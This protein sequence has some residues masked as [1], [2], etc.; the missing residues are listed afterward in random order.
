MCIPSA[1]RVPSFVCLAVL[2]VSLSLSAKALAERATVRLKDGSAVSGELQTY[3][4]GDH[5]TIVLGGKVVQFAAAETASVELGSKAVAPPRAEPR[6]ALPARKARLALPITLTSIGAATM[7]LGGIV[8]AT[9]KDDQDCPDGFCQGLQNPSAAP[10]GKGMMIGG[11]VVTLV[12]L[13]LLPMELAARV[14]TAEVVNKRSY[15]AERATFSPWFVLRDRSG[16][17]AGLSGA[18]RF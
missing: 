7:L 3:V 2:L 11:A 8:F 17:A 1:R 12:G 6:T 18:L 16:T 13:V 10:V 9:M 15:L 4:P 14:R 5:V